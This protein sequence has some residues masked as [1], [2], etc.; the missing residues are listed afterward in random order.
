MTA[1]T[2]EEQETVPLPTSDFLNET[3]AP[4][5]LWPSSGLDLVP[6]PHPVL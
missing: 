6:F 3:K 2:E 4:P 1:A 5:H